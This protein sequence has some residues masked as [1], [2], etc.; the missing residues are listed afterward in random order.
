MEE[1]IVG[2]HE[3]KSKTEGRDLDQNGAILQVVTHYRASSYT[4]KTNINKPLNSSLERKQGS[5]IAEDRRVGRYT[6][7][8]IE[9]RVWT[10]S[11]QLAIPQGRVMDD[12]YI[13]PTR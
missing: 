9:I 6:T 4:P 1:F 5:H 12:K 8:V 7:E 13:L 3:N 11:L 10:K 2:D